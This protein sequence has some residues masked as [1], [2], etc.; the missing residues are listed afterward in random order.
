MVKPMRSH[1]KLLELL[2]SCR[3]RQVIVSLKE[4]TDDGM[5]KGAQWPRRESYPQTGPARIVGVYSP[6][7]DLASIQDDA[8]A[9]EQRNRTGPAVDVLVPRPSPPRPR[10]FFDGLLTGS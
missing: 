10:Q 1:R 8:D 2:P 4:K 7:V 5:L 9:L 6:G 3:D